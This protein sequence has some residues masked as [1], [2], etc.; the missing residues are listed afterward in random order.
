MSRVAPQVAASSWDAQYHIP[1]ALKLNR[2]GCNHCLRTLGIKRDADRY[3]NGELN[4]EGVCPVLAQKVLTKHESCGCKL[5]YFLQG[6]WCPRNR[7]PLDC[8]TLE[9]N[10]RARCGWCRQRQIYDSV[11]SRGSFCRSCFMPQSG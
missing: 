5:Q 10:P 3:C 4:A 6:W 2:Q 9:W 11:D 1:E 7:L 8:F